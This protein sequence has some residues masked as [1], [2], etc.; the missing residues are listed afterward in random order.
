MLNLIKGELFK[1]FNRPVY[2]TICAIF[3]LLIF[4]YGFLLKYVGKIEINSV[5]LEIN[6]L[7]MVATNF[8]IVTIWILPMFTDLYLEEYKENTFKNLIS[9]SLPRWK[10]YLGKYITQFIIFFLIFA[11]SIVTLI[12][13]SYIFGYNTG[14]GELNQ[15]TDLTMKFLIAMPLYLGALAFY[16]LVTIITKKETIAMLS[17]YSI[18]I[19]VNIIGNVLASI[20]GGIFEVINSYIIFNEPLINIVENGMNLETVFR[21]ITSGTLTAIIFLALGVLV[22]N[23]QEIK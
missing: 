20:K 17:M 10:F 9:S 23:K 18:V 19:G 12:I 2:I 15:F 1:V 6:P 4:A 11:T 7:I 16:N 21:A 22:I 8:I 3:N 14:I 13:T 5:N